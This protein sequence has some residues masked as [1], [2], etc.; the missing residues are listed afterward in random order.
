MKIL[1]VHNRY[2]QAGGEDTVVC[3]ENDLLKR[4]GHDV[5]VWKESNESI[6][7]GWDA[8]VTGLQCVYSTGA[9]R[10]MQQR[11]AE[12]RPDLVHIHN[13][14][15]PMNGV[16]GWQFRALCGEIE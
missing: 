1:V 15:P 4:N 6:L 5:E 10:E 3:A 11:I 7:G 16:R 9:A 2:R 13:F 14:F 8:Y 12:F